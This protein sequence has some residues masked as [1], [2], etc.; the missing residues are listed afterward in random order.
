MGAS[1]QAFIAPGRLDRELLRCVTSVVTFFTLTLFRAPFRFGKY[2]QCNILPVENGAHCF[3]VF[4]F[5]R[6]CRFPTL[7]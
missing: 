5:R 3:P 4:V 7:R 6:S 2:C 1:N